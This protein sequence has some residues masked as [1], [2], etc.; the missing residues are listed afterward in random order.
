M[1]LADER[2]TCHLL[3]C[4]MQS[5]QSRRYHQTIDRISLL[6]LQSD[7]HSGRAA[8]VIVPGSY[9]KPCDEMSLRDRA[10]VA[11]HE[12]PGT[13]P[14]RKD[15]PVGCDV[16]VSRKFRKRSITTRNTFGINCA[17]GSY[18]A[19]RDGSFEGRFP[20]HFVP[21]Y[22]YTALPGQ[23]TGKNRGAPHCQ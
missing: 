12:V 10:I 19:L 17:P 23:P 16:T 13:A 20:R 7:V 22:D 21:G 1:R 9:L 18:R 2:R 14:P 8:S 4:E 5:P 15:P 11:C 3:S 6:G